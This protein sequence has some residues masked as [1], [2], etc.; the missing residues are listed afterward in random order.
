MSKADSAWPW[1]DLGSAGN[2]SKGTESGTVVASLCISTSH[3]LGIPRRLSCGTEHS[4][5]LS[6]LFK[7]G[8]TIFLRMASQ[9]WG[10]A[11][12]LS[13]CMWI[14]SRHYC[15]GTR[16]CLYPPVS[17]SSLEKGAAGE[18]WDCWNRCS[19]EKRK[20]HAFLKQTNGNPQVELNER[21]FTAIIFKDYSKIVESRYI[22]V[23]WFCV[24]LSLTVSY[25]TALKPLNPI[26]LQ[27]VNQEFANVWKT[28]RKTRLQL[29]E[30]VMQKSDVSVNYVPS[31]AAL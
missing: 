23:R 11:F 7:N 28:S 5:L 27:T 20:I 9:T 26:L 29:V 4:K 13:T 8:K 3:A 2:S 15:L 31:W 6:R 18:L 19:E 10:P 25:T 24:I 14:N 30:K 17:S 16:F 1:R 22:L 12:Y 21:Y